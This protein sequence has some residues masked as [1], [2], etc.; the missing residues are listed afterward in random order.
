MLR[1][2]NV[3]MYNVSIKKVVACKVVNNLEQSGSVTDGKYLHLA[4][5]HN[6]NKSDPSNTI[7]TTVKRSFTQQLILVQGNLKMS[8]QLLHTQT[9]WSI[10]TEI[11]PH[12]Q[13]YSLL[14][15][16][17]WSSIPELLCSL[18]N[19]FSFPK[20]ITM[21]TLVVVKKM[22]SPLQRQGVFRW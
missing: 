21:I 10:K 7:A 9:C 22:Y 16:M 12:Y 13:L 18:W 8:C 20:M 4:H 6:Y 17:G 19:L 2:L 1:W 5:S 14:V 11:V 15:V 3:L